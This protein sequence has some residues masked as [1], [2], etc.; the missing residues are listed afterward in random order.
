[1]KT[2]SILQKR[3]P[4]N[5]K[6]NYLS[7]SDIDLF[8]PLRF[9]YKSFIHSGNFKFLKTCSALNSEYEIPNPKSNYLMV[10]SIYTD[11]AF[12]SIP[13]K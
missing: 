13:L 3:N 2:D 10:L 6:V 9:L 1:M 5:Y 4:F 12:A 8:V 7:K 11:S